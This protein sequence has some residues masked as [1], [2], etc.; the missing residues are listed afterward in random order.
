MRSK[1]KTSL[2][3][4]NLLVIFFLWLFATVWNLDKAF[5]IDDNH[6][7]DFAQ[8]I[9]NNPFRPMSGS[10]FADHEWIAI[11]ATNQPSLYFYLMAA[12]GTL[13]GWSELSMH[14][15]LAIF[16][17]FAIVAFYH[18]CQNIISKFSL[19][20]TA[21]LALSPAFV[22]GQN[23]MVDIPLLA[24]WISFFAIATK[25][26]TK[27]LKGYLALS[28]LCSVA[29]LTKYTSLILLPALFLI[30][31]LERDWKKLGF[32]LIPLIALAL[33]S[34]W[35]YFDFGQVHLFNRKASP[36]SWF[37]PIR[38]SFWWIGIAGAISPFALYFFYCK[39]KLAKQDNLWKQQRLWQFFLV[40]N[41]IS[42][43]LVLISVA[44]PL[45]D[46]IT[47]LIFNY[48]FLANGLGMII[49]ALNGTHL[50]SSTKFD[51]RLA[52][53]WYW[54]V[55]SFLFIVAFTPFMAMRHVLLALPAIIILCFYTFEH[56]PSQVMTLIPLRK[57]CQYLA[58][59]LTIGI[60]S[61]LA[62]AD[63]WFAHISREQAK[64]I[65]SDIPKNSRIWFT[66]HWGWAWYAP[67]EGMLPLDKRNI[68]AQVGD[69]FVHNRF[70]AKPCCL[71]LSPIKVTPIPYTA[72][73][74]HYATTGLYSSDMRPWQYSNT[75]INT[76]TVYRI[77]Q[78]IPAPSKPVQS[79]G[80]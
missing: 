10:V 30:I 8:W 76:F 3:S 72:W 14:S 17:F 66:G 39:A 21:C 54:V 64:L 79:P 2:F 73:Y 58:L 16:S 23:T 65:A 19:F 15:L 41:L 74:Q 80:L 56:L 62:A 68:Q 45:S 36:K 55:A 24:I 25:S 59:G 67:L 31:Y 70:A 48:S 53:L 78:V 47:N 51:T 28:L 22:T 1:S 11:H 42:A 33:W 75:P 26:Q 20:A 35:N 50:I 77:E 27:T 44:I 32:L 61:L 5:H 38:H 34:L 37:A 7:L 63:Y 12:W 60:T 18:L 57:A 4:F 49:L 40:S 6:H 69:Y 46:K 29:I 52:I 43:I 9:A 71:V 13:F